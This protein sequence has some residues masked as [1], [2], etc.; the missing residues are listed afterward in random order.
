M[1]DP[2]V[3]FDCIPVKIDKYEMSVTQDK[4]EKIIA[5]NY[6]SRGIEGSVQ[7]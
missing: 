4:N 3:V 5:G 2:Y 6:S 1:D 7:K